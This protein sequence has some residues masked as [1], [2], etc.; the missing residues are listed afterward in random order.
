MTDNSFLFARTK[1]REED[2]HKGWLALVECAK[3]KEANDSR[4]LTRNKSFDSESKLC[5]SAAIGLFCNRIWVDTGRST[6]G[7]AESFNIEEQRFFRFRPSR[8]D[9]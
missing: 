1:R 9:G 2:P 3:A 5:R 7:H 6:V 8:N 4:V